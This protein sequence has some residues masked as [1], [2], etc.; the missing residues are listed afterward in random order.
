MQW[1]VRPIR[2]NLVGWRT[3]HGRY[4]NRLVRCLPVLGSGLFGL[5]FVMLSMPV[6]DVA[7]HIDS[8]LAGNSAE[9]ADLV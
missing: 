5:G 8:K 4:I 1:G 6:R 7:S 3:H 2:G 9:S